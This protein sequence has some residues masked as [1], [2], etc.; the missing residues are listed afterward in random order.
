MVDDR[1]PGIGMSHMYVIALVV[2]IVISRVRVKVELL[3]YEF[4]VNPD[5]RLFP[6]GV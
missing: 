3:A 6:R 2:S 4:P 5:I 1:V